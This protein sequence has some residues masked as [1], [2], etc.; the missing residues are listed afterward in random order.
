MTAA[1]LTTG[2]RLSAAVAWSRRIGSDSLYRN[3]LMLMA[4]AVATTL[5]GGLF[6]LLAARK[7][8]A[9]DVGILLATLST[10]A[11]LATASSLGMPNAVVRFLPRRPA[12]SGTLTVTAAVLTATCAAS[13]FAVAAL[14]PWAPPLLRH[15]ASAELIAL[16]FGT[17]VLFA[18]AMTMDATFIAQRSAHLLLVKNVA[19]GSLKLAAVLLLPVHSLAALAGIN[20][21]GLAVSAGVT[22]VLMRPRL[23]RPLAFRLSSLSG[24]WSF[25]LGNHAGMICG[26]LPLTATP[27]IILGALGAEKAAFFG[28][29]CMLMG[30]LSVIPSTFS[31]SLFAELSAGAPERRRHEILRAAKATY[32]LL[33]PAVVVF[34]VA[35]PLMLR[36]F[37]DDYSTNGTACLRWMVLGALVAGTNYLVDVIVNSKGHAGSYLWL[38]ASNA[39]FV[40]GCCAIGARY[41]LA[42]AGLGWLIAQSLS[43]VVGVG[44]LG[45]LS[46]PRKSAAHSHAQPPAVAIPD[47]GPRPRRRLHFL[48]GAR[49]LA[50]MFV[51]VSHSWSTVFP[52]ARN[53]RTQLE[54]LTSWMGLGRYAVSVFIVISG[55]SLGMIAWRHS[56]RWPGGVRAFFRGRFRR[57]V[58]A[59]WVAVAFGAAL[60]A[61]LL[62][63]PVGTLWDGAIPI[64]V[65]GVVDHL[66][67]LQDVH[68]AGPA[69]STAFW[70]L[71][72]EFH[73]Y[74]LF[75]FLLLLLR[76]YPRS[77]PVP[78]L[79]FGA[80]TALSEIGPHN[81][82]TAWIGGLRPSLYGLFVL[83]LMAA[84]AVGDEDP[85]AR[86]RR[87]QLLLGLGLLGLLVVAA[88]YQSFDP[89]SPLNDLW[90]GPAV[91]LVFGRLATGSLRWVRRC[92][93]LRPLVLVGACS[94]SLY[95]IHSA[96]I[97][98]VWRVVV[99]PAG[100]SPAGEL[101]AEIVLGL[102]A[103]IAAAAL[104]YRLVE[105]RFLSLNAR[106]ATVTDA[107]AA[108]LA[109]PAAPP[110]VEV[111]EVAQA[112]SVS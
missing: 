18:A 109:A 83:G 88:S 48:D 21:F 67:L 70:S 72:V 46:L 29:A 58:P 7:F 54:L 64:R 25:S 20:L 17:V 86:R 61:T 5:L 50:A 15:N 39:A 43:V 28:I 62:S 2:S 49:G 14:T 31:Q 84:R 22:V 8:S 111:L 34:L 36:A 47:L 79:V 3:S 103:S 85:F 56:L 11:L 35:A 19:G 4:N 73:I 59:Y 55:F 106:S 104:F 107:A 112:A 30:M 38:N 97:E 94:Y 108:R 66:L 13:V 24:A 16:G 63:H 40:L 45:F 99:E 69:G 53:Q 98:S 101:A 81:H 75:P 26:V 1:D 42:A 100:L 90:F 57:I 82:V 87:E 10:T 78:V 74:L 89:V 71:A 37:G 44:Y 52:Q 68:W 96:I 32:L 91:A 27:L 110:S 93:E 23:S 80:L 6:W 105:R 12:S 41:G 33:G 77:W 102:A 51:V 95:L 9:A 76:R 60:G 92:L 65:P